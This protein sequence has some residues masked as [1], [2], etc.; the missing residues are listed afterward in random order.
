MGAVKYAARIDAPL[1][2][3]ADLGGIEE[4]LDFIVRPNTAG[5]GHQLV[6]IRSEDGYRDVEGLVIIEDISDARIIGNDSPIVVEVYNELTALDAGLEP[7]RVVQIAVDVR[8]SVYFGY[9]YL[10]VSRREGTQR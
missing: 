8:G 4:D 1:I 9:H 6:D 2:G 5:C 7:S 3:N 10:E